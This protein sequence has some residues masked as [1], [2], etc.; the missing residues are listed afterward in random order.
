[1]RIK[2]NWLSNTEKAAWLCVYVC[3][4]KGLS[5]LYTHT[6]THSYKVLMAPWWS[7]QLSPL[8]PLLVAFVTKESPRLRAS[9]VTVS[10]SLTTGV[11]NAHA[12]FNQMTSRDGASDRHGGAGEE[13]ARA[14]GSDWDRCAQIRFMQMFIQRLGA[15]SGKT[16]RCSG[17]LIN[18]CFRHC[19]EKGYPSY[20]TAAHFILTINAASFCSRHGRGVFCC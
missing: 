3:C 6:H 8:F 10:V 17:K 11:T 1:M 2:Q 12:E 13:S 7:K 5:I 18:D 14:K 19:S 16:S 20:I 15:R 9:V 4:N